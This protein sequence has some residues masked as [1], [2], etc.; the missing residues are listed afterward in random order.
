M[1]TEHQLLE[2]KVNDIESE[3]VNL[4]HEIGSL[5]NS[6][7]NLE[8]Q[9]KTISSEV[10]MMKT[11]LGQP[12]TDL[13]TNELRGHVEQQLRQARTE[14]LQ[15]FDDI[16]KNKLQ[17]GSQMMDTSSDMTSIAAD[18][19]MELMEQYALRDC[20]MFLDWKKKKEKIQL[21]R[22]SKL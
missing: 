20:L 16:L 9:K 1:K 18:C 7:R 11:K 17:L 12:I 15:S 13:L 8:E 2:N 6:T 14:I 5:R 22:S 10:Q 4:R 21:R 19:R 3:T